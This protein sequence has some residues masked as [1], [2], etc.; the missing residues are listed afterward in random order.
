MSQRSFS[1]GV[2]C[3]CVSSKELVHPVDCE[4]SSLMHENLCQS[5]LIIDH[6]NGRMLGALL[7][8]IGVAVL[9]VVFC[10]LVQSPVAAMSAAVVFAALG[11]YFLLVDTRHILFV[12][13]GVLYWVQHHGKKRQYG[14]VVLDDV[15]KII[16]SWVLRKDGENKSGTG[17]I[18]LELK[19]GERVQIPSTVWSLKRLPEFYEILMMYNEKIQCEEEERPWGDW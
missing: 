16:E 1:I 19:N 8:C 14:E 15:E 7:L 3:C 9:V 2:A 5:S 17:K 12:D 13:A 6:G 4:G 10:D 18:F 11:V